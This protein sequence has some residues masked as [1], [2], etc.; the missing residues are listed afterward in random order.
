MV[1]PPNTVFPNANL[2]SLCSSFFA[3]KYNDIKL[4][5]SSYKTLLTAQSYEEKIENATYRFSFYEK[6]A[7]SFVKN[8][9]G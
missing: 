5:S 3:F 4:Y 1:P 9:F 6:T 2:I 8:E 7:V